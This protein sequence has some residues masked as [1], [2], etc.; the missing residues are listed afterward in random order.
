MPDLAPG[1]RRRGRPPCGSA[2]P[3]PEA[4]CASTKPSRI[5]SLACQPDSIRCSRAAEAQAAAP[6]ARGPDTSASGC[7]LACQDS[8]PTNSATTVLGADAQPLPPA[9]RI[10]TRS[11]SGGIEGGAVDAQ[12]DHRQQRPREPG[13]AQPLAAATGHSCRGSA[14]RCASTAREVQIS[15]SHGST[16]PVSSSPMPSIAR[17]L[18]VVWVTPQMRPAPGRRAAA[19]SHTRRGRGPAASACRPWPAPFSRPARP[20]ASAGRRCARR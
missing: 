4:F 19:A 10:A 9:R 18:A 7:A 20:S 14:R 16:G 3:A 15:A 1:L 17:W 2:P 11:A 8:R 13:G 5:Q 6:P 12:R